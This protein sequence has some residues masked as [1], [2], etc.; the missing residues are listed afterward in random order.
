MRWWVVVLALLTAGCS[1]ARHTEPQRTAT[2]EMQVS[3]AADRAASQI[4]LTALRGEKVFVDAAYYKGLDPNYTVAAVQEAVLKNG[5]LLVGDRKSAD[6]VVE[7]RNGSQSIDKRQLLIG[8]PAFGLPTTVP[9]LRFEP[10]QTTQ[11]G[12]ANNTIQLPEVALYAKAQNIGVSKL[13]VTAYDTRSGA[14]EA[15]SGPLYGFSH[16]IR[17]TVL[18]FIKWRHQDFRPSEQGRTAKGN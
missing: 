10:G 11:T 15:S 16:A 7:M 5:A 13:T 3:A 12:A 17:Y 14:Y 8:T 1:M 18:I 6:A 4:D 2:E 9:K